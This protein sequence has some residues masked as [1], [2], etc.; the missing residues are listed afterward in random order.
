[1]TAENFDRSFA[2]MIKS[3]GGFVNDPADKGGRTNLGVTQAVWEEYVRHPVGEKEMRELT[4]ET[5]RPLYKSKYWNLIRGDE[6]PAGVDY[7]TFDVAVNSG[8]T[9]AI[10]F[11]QLGVG[12]TADGLIG[13]ITMKHVNAMPADDLIRAICQERREF[14]QRLS[15]FDR[16]GKGWMM[17]V[18]HVEKTALE[19]ANG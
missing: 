19:M 17:R 4:V 14:L 13:A 7:A 6:L 5:V 1:M 16:F 8:I 18:N 9:R 15:N 11:L 12:V 3:E 2:L 10:R